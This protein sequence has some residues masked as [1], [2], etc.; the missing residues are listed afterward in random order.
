M[1][2]AS[3]LTA[4][5][6]FSSLLGVGSIALALTV[7]VEAMAQQPAPPAKEQGDASA[8]TPK[9]GAGTPTVEECITA[10]REGQELRRQLRLME[11]R[12]ILTE[13]GSASCPGPV[14]R[15]CLRWVDEIATQ[16]PS[17]VFR[18][19]GEGGE[20]SRN[21]RIFV[22][23]E[24][25]FQVVPNRAVE[26]NPGTYRFR[27]ESDGKPPIEQEVVLGEA[28]KFKA[29]TIK[30]ASE[31]KTA[32]AAA[33]QSVTTA[34]PLTPTLSAPAKSESRP[35]PLATYLFAGLGVVATANFVGWGLS[36]KSLVSDMQDRCAP[37]CEQVYID[38]ARTRALV[39]DISLGVGVASFATA[40]LF[41]FLRP[42]VT[43]PV[44]MDVGALPHGGF[45]G[46]VRVTAF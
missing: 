26:F 9:T 29:V 30:F 32:D 43:R 22:E 19:D 18:V 1:T 46:S 13:C 40:T 4:P 27:F 25:R 5:T 28:E 21:I 45:I 20:S 2:I 7:T 15:D 31:S 8:P 14:K 44:E 38:R 33:A 39:A 11:A 24:L 10:H 6:R 35:V 36:S 12:G 42:T 3:R 41:Y 16:L 34:K 23:N 17:I 37:D